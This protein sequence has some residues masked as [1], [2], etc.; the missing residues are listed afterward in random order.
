MSPEDFNRVL[1]AC[2]SVTDRLLARLIALPAPLT[3]IV[4]VIYT[5]LVAYVGHRL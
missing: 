4:I 5:V 2:D 3:F 1:A